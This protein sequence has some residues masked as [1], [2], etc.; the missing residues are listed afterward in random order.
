MGTICWHYLNT[1]PSPVHPHVRGDNYM[2]LC[3]PFN[4]SGSPPRAWGQ[5]MMA[6]AR[7]TPCRFTPTCVGTIQSIALCSSIK[8]VHPH[9]RGDNFWF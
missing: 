3:V 8:S 4:P 1:A 5:L 7:R 6:G 2:R 9:V